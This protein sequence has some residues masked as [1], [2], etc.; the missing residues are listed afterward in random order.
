VHLSDEQRRLAAVAGRAWASSADPKP[1][2]P[3]VPG[4]PASTRAR[5]DSLEAPVDAGG[6]LG[7]ERRHCERIGLASQLLLRPVGGFNCEVK[8][9][10]VSVAGCQVELIEPA[11]PGET[12][13][14]R[15]PQLEP[16]GADVRWSQGTTAGLE[17]SRPIHSAVLDSLL[18][19]L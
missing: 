4:C 17:F 10:N 3:H 6:E 13:I 16:I 5:R 15:F 9:D 14:T 2:D 18:K 1:V 8:L 12:M 11:E 19:R 7:L